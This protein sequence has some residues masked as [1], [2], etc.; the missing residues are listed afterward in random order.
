MSPFGPLP[1]GA[2]APSP[3]P[4]GPPALRVCTPSRLRPACTAL[5]PREL[6]G[7]SCWVLGGAGERQSGS[8]LL[9][10]A[11]P[12]RPPH[13]WLPGWLRAAPRSLL[14]GPF[15]SGPSVTISPKPVAPRPVLATPR[16]SVVLGDS[17]RLCDLAA[18]AVYH[19][20]PPLECKLHKGG[21]SGVSLS[22]RSR[23]P[24]EPSVQKTLSK[25]GA[26][27]IV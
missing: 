15:L 3:P 11:R 8:A 21:S 1:I 26:V 23:L 12:P 2:G 19:L 20:R 10:L 7:P 17:S 25:Q 13:L 16:S 22:A 6:G 5:G 14:P 4:A 27:C 24:R 9:L 18:R